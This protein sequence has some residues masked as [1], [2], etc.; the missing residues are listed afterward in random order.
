MRFDV[1]I[2]DLAKFTQRVTTTL[3][4]RQT[5]IAQA[6]NQIGMGVRQ[7][8]AQQVARQTG[9]SAE[10]IMPLIRMKRASAQIKEV[11]ISMARSLMEPGS[12]DFQSARRPQRRSR[13]RSDFNEGE[14]VN[15]IT[16]EDEKVCPACE[17]LAEGSPYTIED[18]R[19]L[20]PHHPR[21]RCL[22][23]SF[24]FKQRLPVTFTSLT[25]RTRP[26]SQ[27]VSMKT[28]AKLARRELKTILRA[29]R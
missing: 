10:Q 9:M 21:C 27:S 1:E 29:I 4:K 19:T 24:K 8:L 23:E 25:G 12:D 16:R 7:E 22:L 14:L 17:D 28:L 20:I 6:L 3:A 11:E 26:V 15:I 13:S 5:G 18:A 2:P